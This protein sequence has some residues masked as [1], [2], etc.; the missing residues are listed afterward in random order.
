MTAAK[1]PVSGNLKEE[2]NSD[3]SD[4]VKFVMASTSAITKTLQKRR[5]I[6]TNRD[7]S[8]SD[9]VIEI[10]SKHSSRSRSRSRWGEL[11]HHWKAEIHFLH[12]HENNLENFR[13]KVVYLS[14]MLLYPCRSKSPSTRRYRH[15]TKHSKKRQKK[16]KNRSRSRTSRY[17]GSKVRKHRYADD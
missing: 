2:H 15:K 13:L 14:H 4:S 5:H 3:S 9:D 7:S 1:S 6:R 10:T 8:A 16:H 12:E 17:S 11:K